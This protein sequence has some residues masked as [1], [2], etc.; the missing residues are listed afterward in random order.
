MATATL[1]LNKLLLLTMLGHIGFSNNLPN[2]L[3]TLGCAIMVTATF[4]L[5]TESC[6]HWAVPY[7]YS[8][9]LPHK[10]STIKGLSKRIK[11]TVFIVKLS[12]YAWYASTAA[13]ISP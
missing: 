11:A 5:N 12:T 8:N 6:L 4:L 9:N 10:L 3:S 1:L 2:K 7:S 13:T